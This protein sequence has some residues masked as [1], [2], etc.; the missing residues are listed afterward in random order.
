MTSQVK[1]TH[2][3]EKPCVFCGWNDPVQ[4]CLRGKCWIDE[5]NPDEVSDLMELVR[6]RTQGGV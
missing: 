1:E 3:K 2:I 5:A 4:G 6:L